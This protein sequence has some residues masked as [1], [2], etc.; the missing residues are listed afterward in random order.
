[1]VGVLLTLS[2]Q[3]GEGQVV[4]VECGGH[5]TGPAALPRVQGAQRVV[6]RAERRQA[7]RRHEPARRPEHISRLLALLPLGAPVLE[8]YLKHTITFLK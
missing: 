2:G 7:G 5:L 6:H 3:R 1:V 8:P 4:R